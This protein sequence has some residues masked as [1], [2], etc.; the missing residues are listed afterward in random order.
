MSSAAITDEEL[1]HLRAIAKAV[2]DDKK[3]F[4]T[5]SPTGEMPYIVCRYCTDVDGDHD[6]DCA[7]TL[8][9]KLA[10]LAP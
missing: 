8:A 5:I 2:A 7:Y 6:A 9:R 3:W 10:G 1:A 4:E